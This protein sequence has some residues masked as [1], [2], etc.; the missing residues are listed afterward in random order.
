MT[1]KS[2][3]DVRIR[4]LAAMRHLLVPIAR[5]LI[6]NGIT[7]GDFDQVA[8]HAFV[9]AGVSVLRERNLPTTI[10]RISLTTLLSQGEVRKIMNNSAQIAPLRS[11]TGDVAAT[12]LNA[13]HTKPPFVVPPY[14]IPMDLVYDAD[15]TRATFVELVRL[16]APGANPSEVLAEL[17][18]AGA[19]TQDE[20]GFLHAT[21]RAFVTEELSQ[22]QIEYAAKAA[23]RF[24]DTLDTNL[25]EAGRRTGRFERS[26]YADQGVPVRRYDD[27]VA[28]IRTTLQ[29]TLIDID[30]WISANATPSKGEPVVWT[31]VGMYHWLEQPE[32]FSVTFESIKAETELSDSGEP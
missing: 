2:T 5:I 9:K 1:K 26:V 3:I 21:S 11:Q 24:L 10:S 6:R 29:K 13:W 20:K 7:Y 31:G 22:E 28:F 17:M 16:H 19:V 12:V 23:R 4:L 8:R 14:G 15:D 25:T 30:Q 27:F 18:A 32:D